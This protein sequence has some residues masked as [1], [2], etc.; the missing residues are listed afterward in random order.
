MLDSS[1]MKFSI[2]FKEKFLINLMFTAILYYTNRIPVL[3]NVSKKQNQQIKKIIQ[4]PRKLSATE[5]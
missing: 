5:L 3:K 2:I 4:F 1:K